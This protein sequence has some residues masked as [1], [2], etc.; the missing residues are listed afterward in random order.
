M[1]EI[2]ENR[3]TI[4]LDGSLLRRLQTRA[5]ATDTTESEVLPGCAE[6][7]LKVWEDDAATRVIEKEEMV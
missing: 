2:L 3:I 7:A 4:R 1:H 6:F 5:I